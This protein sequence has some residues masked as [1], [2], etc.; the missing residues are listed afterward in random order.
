MVIHSERW[1]SRNLTKMKHKV[2][3]A[4]TSITVKDGTIYR[5]DNKMYQVYNGRYE[6]MG[7]ICE[8]SNEDLN[9]IKQHHINL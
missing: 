6:Y 5:I 1:L 8:V 3:R 9:I 4:W 7:T 2:M